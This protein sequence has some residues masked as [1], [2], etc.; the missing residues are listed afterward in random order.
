MSVCCSCLCTRHILQA[1]ATNSLRARVNSALRENNWSLNKNLV[2]S[3]STPLWG[4]LSAYNALKWCFAIF[5]R[6]N[7]FRNVAYSIYIHHY[8]FKIFRVHL[9]EGG[10]FNYNSCWR[11]WTTT[12]VRCIHNVTQI[13]QQTTQ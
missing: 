6:S 10:A 1:T 8:K 11:N 13:L 5:R 2:E 3:V 7:P 4:G 12:I 9:Y